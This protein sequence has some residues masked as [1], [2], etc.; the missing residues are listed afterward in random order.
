MW[1]QSRQRQWESPVSDLVTAAEAAKSPEPRAA[2]FTAVT[3]GVTQGWL[4]LAGFETPGRTRAVD[5]SPVWCE[6]SSGSGTAQIL[7]GIKTS[8]QGLR[9]SQHG[10]EDSSPVRI[11]DLT[12]QTLI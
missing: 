2:R 9:V 1:V 7:E 12:A 6:V 5:W 10:W 3:W 8:C 11:L 4:F